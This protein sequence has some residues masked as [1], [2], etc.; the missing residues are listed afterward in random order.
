LIPPPSHGAH[1]QSQMQA[2]TTTIDSSC[3]CTLQWGI[4][5]STTFSLSTLSSYCCCSS[6]DRLLTRSCAALISSEKPC[7]FRFWP[8]R[9]LQL[10]ARC[11]TSLSDSMKIT[12]ISLPR[13]E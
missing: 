4:F 9:N 11:C 1:E 2:L 5:S 8:P 13:H 12:T 6:G 10:D 7:I 3:T